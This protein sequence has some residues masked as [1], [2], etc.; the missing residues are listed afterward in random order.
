MLGRSV[1]GH[2]CFVFWHWCKHCAFVVKC[3]NPLELLQ[4]SLKPLWLVMPSSKAE[5]FEEL[6]PIKGKKGKSVPPPTIQR[7]WTEMHLS[8][9]FSPDSRSSCIFNT[10]EHLL[11]FFFHK[12]PFKMLDSS[13]CCLSFWKRLESYSWS[14]LVF[15]SLSNAFIMAEL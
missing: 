8:I 12:F 14:Y 9:E 6:E 10:P 1:G 15:L 11:W 3:W 4:R 5:M 7:L 2:A 13:F